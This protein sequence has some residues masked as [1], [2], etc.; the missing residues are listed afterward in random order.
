MVGKL[1]KLAFTLKEPT[2]ELIV[3]FR[4]SVETAG[5]VMVT[6]WPEVIVPEP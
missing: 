6:L 1:N 5:S 3:K 4:L 2:E